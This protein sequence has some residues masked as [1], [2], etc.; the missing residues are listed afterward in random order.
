MYVNQYFDSRSVS[1]SRENK[2]N[3]D[4]EN[5][6]ILLVRFVGRENVEIKILFYQ[7]VHRYVDNTNCTILTRH[8]LTQ[9]KY[10]GLSYVCSCEFRTCSCNDSSEQIVQIF[11]I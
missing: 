5:Y 6:S 10:L 1:F 9:S 7:N 3:Q 8:S 11:A 2:N 4:V